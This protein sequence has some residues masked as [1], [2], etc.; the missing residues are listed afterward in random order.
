[1]EAKPRPVSTLRH[2]M[3]ALFGFGLLGTALDLVLLGHY[4]SGGQIIP[5]ALLGATFAVTI[6]HL[7]QRG[8]ASL[9]AFQGTM[10]LMALVSLLGIYLHFRSN[11]EFQVDIYPDL[12]GWPLFLKVVKAHAPPAMAPGALLQLA[13]LGFL[14]TFRH[15]A[16][17][18]TPDSGDS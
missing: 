3:L 5:L 8:A 18:R 12:A 11:R 4:E 10:V 6:W 15:P 1:M 7:V 17:A 13:L 14:Y 2:L 9:R 16:L